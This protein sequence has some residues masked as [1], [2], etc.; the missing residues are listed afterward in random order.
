V[1]W[2]I[3]PRRST[4]PKE[5]KEN[6]KTRALVEAIAGARSGSVT[7]RK[8]WNFDAP[9]VLAASSSEGSIRSQYAPTPRTTIA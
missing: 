8:V 1:E 9:R 2:L 5:V 3:S 4:T 6:R 7:V